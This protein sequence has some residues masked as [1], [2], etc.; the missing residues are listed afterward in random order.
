[1]IYIKI[2]KIAAI[3]I[4]LKWYIAKHYHALQTVTAA[5]SPSHSLHG[6]VSLSCDQYRLSASKYGA[7]GTTSIHM[8]A[9]VLRN[10][11]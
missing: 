9:P 2:N 4:L 8:T 6:T 5:T 7:W 3:V 10:V 1:M 11:S